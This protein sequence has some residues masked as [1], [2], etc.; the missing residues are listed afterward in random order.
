M[1]MG[2]IFKKVNIIDLIVAFIILLALF[3]VGVRYISIKKGAQIAGSSIAGARFEYTVNI[4]GVRETT[5]KGLQAAQNTTAA[6]TK[7]GANLGTL[8][9]ITFETAT[10]NT[11][12]KN[13]NI[14]KAE[15]PDK[16]D[17]FLTLSAD[18]GTQTEKGYFTQGDKQIYVGGLLNINIGNVQTAGEVTDMIIK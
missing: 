4:K 9:A 11:T 17:V 10:A 15:I 6:E 16:Y 5:L 3:T 1:S 18:Y 8:T 14:T 13:G 2:K 7:T 12:D